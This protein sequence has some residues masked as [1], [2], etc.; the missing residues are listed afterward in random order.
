MVGTSTR[1]PS[2]WAAPQ[3]A[4][5]PSSRFWWL[6]QYPHCQ[7]G[8]AL[9]CARSA[10]SVIV[11]ADAVSSGMIQRSLASFGSPHR[12]HFS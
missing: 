8:P 1:A 10:G 12:W 7:S 4:H 11:G 9:A 6:P 2:A 5:A 3:R